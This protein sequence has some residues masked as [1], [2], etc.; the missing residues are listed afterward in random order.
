LNGMLGSDDT[1]QWWC[2]NIGPFQWMIQNNQIGCLM[3][4]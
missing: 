1:I 3:P 2:W 4:W